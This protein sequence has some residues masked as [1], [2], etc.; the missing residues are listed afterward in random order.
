MLELT[1]QGRTEFIHINQKEYAMQRYWEACQ[2]GDKSAKL[3]LCKNNNGIS[4][5]AV[6][7]IEQQNT[8][9]KKNGFEVPPPLYAP[10]TKVIA[11]GHE[12][13]RLQRQ[14]VEN[15]PLFGDAAN[16]IC[17]RIDQEARTDIK[18]PLNQVVMK[19]DGH[20]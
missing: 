8:W 16:A 11:L 19:A 3:V 15:M 4:Q 2:A 10:G 18:I 7:R 20:M 14:A 6:Q 1:I 12:N 17:H 13:F 5:L 9:L